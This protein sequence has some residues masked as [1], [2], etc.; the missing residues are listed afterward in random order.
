MVKILSAELAVKQH[1]WLHSLDS[2]R[3]A[4]GEENKSLACG[5]GRLPAGSSAEQI[6]DRDSVLSADAF[7]DRLGVLGADE[8]ARTR[9]E[10]G[11]AL[12]A[13]R[14]G[15]HVLI[16]RRVSRA[17]LGEPIAVGGDENQESETEKSAFHCGVPLLKLIKRNIPNNTEICDSVNSL[18]SSKGIVIWRTNI[19]NPGSSFR[20]S[21]R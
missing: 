9:R 3:K 11:D 5:F 8:S 10:A 14:D 6:L 13:L 18:D 12:L 2:K 7:V 4:A 1:V 20:R 15:R 17:G 19:V 16:G 21:S